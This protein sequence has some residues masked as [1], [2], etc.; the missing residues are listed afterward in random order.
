MTYGNKRLT[1]SCSRSGNNAD[2]HAGLTTIHVEQQALYNWKLAARYR[3][4]VT[5]FP[6]PHAYRYF[7]HLMKGLI[8]ACRALESYDL[9]TSDPRAV[10]TALL[11]ETT[12]V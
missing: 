12:F 3:A 8:T 10:R 6:I 9:P 4:E 5:L 7:K 1:C 2:T 11:A